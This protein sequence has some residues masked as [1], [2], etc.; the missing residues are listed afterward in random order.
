MT[1]RQF[2]IDVVRKLQQAGFE[3]LWAGGC[4]RDQLLGIVPKDYDVATAARPEQIRELFGNK[5]TLPIGAAFGVI[6]VLGGKNAGQI[7]VATFRRDSGYSDGRHPDSIEFTDAREDAIRRD[8]TINGMFFD[9]LAEKVIDFVGGQQDL[10]EKLIRAIGDP[11]ERID[12]DKLRMLRGVR[13]ASTFSFELDAETFAAIKQ[14]AAEIQVVSEE[15]IGAELVRM[16][17]HPHKS[18]AARLLLESGLLNA[19]IPKEWPNTD[20]WERKDWDQR[21]KELHRLESNKFEAAIVVLLRSYFEERLSDQDLMT[22]Q[23]KS[24]WRLTNDQ[25][26]SINWIHLNWKALAAAHQKSWSEIQPLLVNAN[27]PAALDVA[28]SILV[29][30]SE[31]D[32]VLMAGIGFCRERL[33]WPRESLDPPPLLDGKDLIRLGILP[34]PE[35]KSLLQS[36]RDSQLDG[37]IETVD[38]AKKFV[39][40]KI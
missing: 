15:R 5:R 35:F 3:A 27:A 25:R 6:T 13:F 18:T 22:R 37:K 8:F 10:A 9:P 11:H 21:W 33:G 1:P 7:E 2:A 24:A 4:V 26:D 36:V 16:L 39:L 40:G 38:Q 23:L 30:K 20:H 17:A 14:H 12:E 29:S 31:S 19:A 34:G 28:T 32:D